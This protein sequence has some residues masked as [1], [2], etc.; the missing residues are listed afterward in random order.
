MGH[1][2]GLITPPVNTADV[3]YV[4]RKGSN[5]VG[6]LC[7]A[8]NTMINKWAKYKPVIYP[9]LIDSTVLN[10][11]VQIN[12]DKT[13]KSTSTWWKAADGKCGFTIGL[14]TNGSA[15]VTNW[16]TDWT[17]NPPTGGLAAPYRLIDFNYYDHNAVNPV[18]VYYPSSYVKAGGNNLDVQFTVYHGN[19]YML[20]LTDVTAGIWNSQAS[21]YCGVLLV[22]G[23]TGTLY[24][25]RTKIAVVNPTA[26]GTGNTDAEKYNRTVS[27]PSSIMDNFVEGAEIQ[28]YPFLCQ[29]AY[30]TQQKGA[31]EDVAW[32]YGVVAC[33]ADMATI[34]VVRAYIT[35][36]L[37]ITRC[38]YLVGGVQVAFNY[39]ITGHNGFQQDS[40][41]PYLYVLDNDIDTSGQYPESEKKYGKHI[42][43]YGG[44]TNNP[45][46]GGAM[47][48]N[49]PDDT[50]MNFTQATLFENST[51]YTVVGIDAAS[52]VADYRSRHGS[53]AAKVTILVEFQDGQ[54][55]AYGSA[56]V[57]DVDIS[58][59]Y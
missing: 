53:G 24:A 44:A 36:A 6:T 23:T 13:W 21:M 40:L 26:L 32:E 5:D 10:G 3:S 18:G 31:N 49:V 8:S 11:I 19:D 57:S 17:Y 33:P 15:L 16:G 25:N 58:G 20:L 54:G 22:A 1:S 45:A 46:V 39:D 41:V 42:I 37:A 4:T 28:I 47:S 29:N 56:S 48:L 52:Y 50:T 12:N 7:G 9:N 43:S 14:R 59:N 30:A 34:Y 55:Y 2:N 35:G 38:S 51:D 27:V